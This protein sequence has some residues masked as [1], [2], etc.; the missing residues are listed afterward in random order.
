ML[1]MILQEGR[2]RGQAGTKRL[3][4]STANPCAAS[5]LGPQTHSLEKFSGMHTPPPH[6][7]SL[8]HPPVPEG[9]PKCSLRDGLPAPDLYFGLHC[10]R[11][12]AQR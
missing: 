4:L 10:Q 7:L 6:H 5:S 1:P 2:R 3:Y 12:R 8:S 11:A 9:W